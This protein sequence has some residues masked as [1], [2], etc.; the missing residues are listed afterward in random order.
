MATQAAPETESHRVD[1]GDVDA[2]QLRAEFLL[3]RRANGLAGIGPAKQQP[4][5]QRDDDGTAKSDNAR[6]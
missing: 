3:C 6:H 2:A 5:Q 1:V 4:Q